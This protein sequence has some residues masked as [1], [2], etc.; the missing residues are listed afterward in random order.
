MSKWE[1]NIAPYMREI[2]DWAS[3][4]AS[5][6]EIAGKL[7][8]AYSTFRKYSKQHEELGA[9]LRRGKNKAKRIMEKALASQDT[10]GRVNT[11]RAKRTVP[12]VKSA[13]GTPRPD[14]QGRHRGPFERNKKKIY[15]TQ[16]ICGICGRP[17]DKSLKYPHPLSP[18]ID[19]IIPVAKGGHPSDLSNLQL[20]HWTCNRQKSDKL[21]AQTEEHKMIEVISNRVLPQ[22]MDWASYRSK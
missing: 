6:K 5:T 2:E 17:V 12:Y 15:A 4:G 20:A 21:L 19:H 14:Q 11:P 10:P 13:P 18:C 8:V 3:R 1:S 9:A 7:N 22:S 16:D